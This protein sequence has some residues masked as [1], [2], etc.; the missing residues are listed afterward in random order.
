MIVGRRG[1]LVCAVVSIPLLARAEPPAAAAPL[2]VALEYEA[3]PACP[4][5]DDFKAVVIGRLGW[6]DA[7]LLLLLG[8]I[9]V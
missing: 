6:F 8:I 1:A 3:A 9:L 4:D 2:A 7:T 5:I